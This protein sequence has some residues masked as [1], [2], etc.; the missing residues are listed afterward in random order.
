[1]TDFYCETCNKTLSNKYWYKKHLLT[2]V[3]KYKANPNLKRDYP[4]VCGKKYSSIQSRYFHRKTCKL[5]A[6]YLNGNGEIT[7]QEVHTVE[8]SL[9]NLD[10]KILMDRIHEFEKNKIRLESTIKEKDAT[11]RDLKQQLKIVK[12]ETKIANN[13]SKT[14]NNNTTNNIDNSSTNNTTNNITN[15]TI[16][17]FGYENDNYI[18]KKFLVE[19]VKDVYNGVP[20]LIKKLHNDPNHPENH[21]IKITDRR[22]KEIKVMGENGEWLTRDRKETVEQRVY[23]LARIIYDAYKDNMKLFPTI[24][25]ERFERYNEKLIDENEPNSALKFV[26]KKTDNAIIDFKKSRRK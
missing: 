7:V 2:D 3:H 12:L 8:Q 14:T 9:E 26:A 15:I 10:P 4:C 11:I 18:T 25:Q 6:D 21:N 23:D 1:M 16:N 17:A 22:L 24:K 5:Y 20:N 19:C 13:N